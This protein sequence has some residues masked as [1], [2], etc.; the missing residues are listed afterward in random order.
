MHLQYDGTTVTTTPTHPFYQPQKG[1]IDA[2]DL[3]AGDI[4]VKS[5]GEYV[6]VEAIEHELLES[7]ITVYNFEVEDFHT[8]YVG[9]T[10]VLVHNKCDAM[11]RGRQMHKQ[12]D[13]GQNKTTFKTEVSIP[14]AG[15]ADAVDFVN[16][17]VYELKPDNLRA[18]RQ[19]WR[20]LN[21]YIV[22]LE[23]MEPGCRWI[24]ILVTYK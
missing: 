3:R 23:A 6:V 24:K 19:G 18:I 22:G 2:I 7:P 13:Y 12:W 16:H 10:S 15:R 4:L 21:R 14:G 17:I 9:D 11:T 5:N 20:Q 1:W 8:Y